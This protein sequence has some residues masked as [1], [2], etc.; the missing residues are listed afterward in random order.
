[1]AGSAVTPNLGANQGQQQ[2]H[3]AH[4][5]QNP[6]RDSVE[7]QREKLKIPEEFQNE[8][9]TL[10][11]TYRTGWA[12]DRLLRI[13]LWIRNLL[14]FRGSQCLGYDVGNNT[15]FDA[16]AWYRQ[17]GQVQDGED[18]YL[19]KYSNNITQMLEAG[20]VGAMSRSLPPTIVKPQNAEVLA[21]ITTAKAASEAMSIIER[22]NDLD[23][24]VLSEN[25]LLYLYAVYFKYTR[26][27]LD[28]D[29]AGWDYEDEF[30]EITVNQP[31][32]YHCYKCGKDTPSDALGKDQ[33]HDCPGCGSPMGDE[34]FYPGQDSQQI[35]LTGQKRVPR[36]MVKWSVHGPLEIDVD[37]SAKT[38]Q[39]TPLLSFDQE[40]DVG[41]LRTSFPDSFESIM[42]GAQVGTTPNASYEK[43]QRDRVYS[44]G[45]GFTDD[46]SNQKPTFSQNWIQPFA[47]AR[48]GNKE[49]ADY[50]NRVCPDGVKMTLVGDLV[51]DMRK[52]N[53]TK[54]WTA[55][56]LRE[57]VGMYPE[58]IADNV[59]PF[60]I[61]LND[62]L[63]II[64][65]WIQRCAAGMTLYDASK[66]DGREIMGKVMS[67]GILNPINTK[68]KMADKPLSDAIFQFEFELDPQIFSYPT[69]LMNL[70]QMISGVTPDI[71]GVG[72]TDE[73]HTNGGQQQMLSVARTKLGIFW[74]NLK[75][76]HAEAAQNALDC[77][78]RLM[79][80]G[81][82]GEIYD[83][84][85]TNG[86]AFR[87]NY[88]DWNKMQGHIKVYPEVDQ[89]L[90]QSEDEIR[91]S[92]MQIVKMA[93][94]NNPI[95][96]AFVDDPTN[97][98]LI[99]STL[100][101][102]GSVAPNQAQEDRTLQAINTLMENDYLITTDPQTGQVM[103][104]LPVMPD[105]HVDDFGLVR[106]IIRHFLQENSDYEKSNP[107]GWERVEKY[108]D[109]SIEMEVQ[110]GMAE[111][112]RGMKVKMAGMP[113]PPPKDPLQQ[114]A[115][116]EAIKDGARAVT[117]LIS[118]AEGPD[119]AQGVNITPKVTAAAK[120]AQIAID[121][122]RLQ[123]GGK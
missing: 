78:Q 112:Q 57:N 28:G 24:M 55:C 18:N 21:D 119:P 47:Y 50:M 110:E 29:W 33:S 60:N 62:T 56:T 75:K 45:W 99:I 22:M 26:P 25:N 74:R 121:A 106:T 66:I 1:M 13:P 12:P 59:V 41:A 63:D 32:R 115:A 79:R 97:Q 19:D 120:V 72:T 7:D 73:S 10:I 104:R 49:F 23:S 118:I 2:P 102:E 43:L 85:Q 17:N 39:D 114:A 42:E 91:Q 92:L 64:D 54:E 76:E 84:I 8:L 81:A 35:S 113:P 48:T 20:F 80:A 96:M 9:K 27:V 4:T 15:Y 51:V 122:Q 88:V 30:G 83:V 111:A 87:N 38:L 77:L 70:A 105:A 123:A 98:R 5:P 67:S 95:A 107:G 71:G 86:S 93:T 89:G 109:M 61:R 14:M 31:D 36:A 103:Q 100:A 6:Q 11:T 101:P 3:F 44:M 90:P 34:A 68:G 116:Q 52:A 82:I 65:D 94:D 108:L 46:T 37:P 69:M 58:S 117:D 16:W 53:L 40:V